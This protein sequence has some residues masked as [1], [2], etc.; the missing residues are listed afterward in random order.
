MNR[1]TNVSFLMGKPFCIFWYFDHMPTELH[2]PDYH[3]GMCPEGEIE[4]ETDWITSNQW[5]TV[6]M[7]GHD[8]YRVFDWYE[9][10]YH[11][12]DIKFGH[13]LDI[14]DE[15]REVRRNTYACGY[16]GHMES[17]AKG[18]VFCTE[19]LGSPYLKENE[20]HLLRMVSV[21]QHL[22]VRKPLTDVERKHLLP[23]YI[24][25][26]TKT[27]SK[28]NQKK[29]QI[30]ETERQKIIKD[31]N[32]KADGLLWLLERNFNIE[33]VIYY[34]HTNKFSFGWKTPVSADV[35]T[36]LQTMLKDFPFEFEIKRKDYE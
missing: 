21:E 23:Q 31:A 15:M 32:I 16:C 2:N 12:R 26:Q 30:I 1:Y 7:N 6:P 8:G 13:Y 20:L 22:P 3:K 27:R 9:A 33:N 36:K 25:A 14:T 35:A 18:N 34:S 4:L 19:C 11:N 10:I 28:S 24:E 17:A 29:S 5:N